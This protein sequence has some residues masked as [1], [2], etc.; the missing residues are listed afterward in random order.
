M[1]QARAA[2]WRRLLLRL[3]LS[4]HIASIN[5]PSNDLEAT[6]NMLGQCLTRYHS[7]VLVN[8]QGSSSGE[9]KQKYALVQ[10]RRLLELCCY[11]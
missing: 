3:L 8:L 7:Y 4:L 10:Y 2:R 9:L 1:P 6:S 11:L 5:C